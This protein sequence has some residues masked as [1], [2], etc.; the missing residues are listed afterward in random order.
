MGGTQTWDIKDISK[1]IDE[2][3]LV[4]TFE[5]PF[6]FPITVKGKGTFYLLGHGHGAIKDG[7]IFRAIING[8]S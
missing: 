2:K 6:L 7:E 5:E 4:E 3:A 1:N 8:R